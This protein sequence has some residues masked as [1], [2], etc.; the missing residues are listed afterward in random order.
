MDVIEIIKDAF[1]FPSKDIKILVIYVLLSVL[2]GAF[3]FIGTFV[4]ILG[5][6]IPECFMW[7]GMAVIVSMLIGWILSGY[8]ISVIKSGIELD[9]KVPGFE[10]WDNF[11]TGF[12]NFIVT[13]VYFIIPAFIVAVVGYITNVFG[14]FMIIARE[15]I[16]LAQNVY[17]GHS[18]VLVS[19]AMAHAFANL[20]VSLAVTFTVA[21]V[22]FVIFS[23]LQ[24]MAQARLANTGSLSEALNV[25]EA[26][27][28]IARIG[29]SKVI[30]IVLLIIVIVAVVEM[31]LSTFISF[32][33]VLSILS[34]IVTPYMT[35]FAQRAVGL[36]YSDIA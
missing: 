7:G 29:V 18:T 3:S 23:F 17:M 36:L 24:T 25:F 30:I 34:I 12:N 35:F 4:Y 19:D 32:S 14:N 5:V 22:L 33:P 13:I 31:I 16:S 6:I 28:D 2:A 20:V 9:D 27:K 11:I 26:V 1:V 15:I 8:L 10:W 21:I